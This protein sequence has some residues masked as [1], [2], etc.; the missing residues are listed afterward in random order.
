[1]QGVARGKAHQAQPY[2]TIIDHR[3]RPSDGPRKFS[4]QLRRYGQTKPHVAPCYPSDAN[5]VHK[6]YQARQTHRALLTVTHRNITCLLH[7]GITYRFHRFSNRHPPFNSHKEICCKS[8]APAFITHMPQL[9]S[10]CMS[11]LLCKLHGPTLASLYTSREQNNNSEANTSMYLSAC[12]M[13]FIAIKA[14]QQ[15]L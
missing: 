11:Q 10:T 4:T 2:V 14:I 5:W 6:H 13:I 3:R 1:M 12:T 7:T 9:S 8:V 15:I